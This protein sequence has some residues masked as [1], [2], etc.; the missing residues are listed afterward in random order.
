LVQMEEAPHKRRK[1]LARKTVQ[2]P[3]LTPL[4]AKCGP[5]RV[6]SEVL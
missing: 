5:A 6:R 1:L 4:D 3:V 2:K